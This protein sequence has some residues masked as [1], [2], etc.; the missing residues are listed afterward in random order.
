MGD[1]FYGM[2]ALSGAI[3][4]LRGS[5]FYSNYIESDAKALGADLS[6]QFGKDKPC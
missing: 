4:F 1:V 3:Q 6:A 5:G 2:Y